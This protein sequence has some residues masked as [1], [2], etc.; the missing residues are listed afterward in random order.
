MKR[1][2]YEVWAKC[3]SEKEECVIMKLRGTFEHITDASIF[4]AAYEKN[5]SSKTV[6]IRVDKD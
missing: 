4:A 2:V 3:W 6:T 1:T 5:V